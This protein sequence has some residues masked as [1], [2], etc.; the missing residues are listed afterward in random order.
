MKGL[1]KLALVTAIAA[2]PFAA[3]ADLKALDDTAMGDVTGQAGVSIELGADI[4]VGEIAYQ[5]EGFLAINGLHLSGA[6]KDTNPDSRLDNILVKIDVAGT[7]NA[8]LSGGYGL[9]GLGISDPRV[10]QPAIEDGDLVIHLGATELAANPLESVDFGLSIESIGLAKSGATVGNLAAEQGTVLISDLNLTGFIGPIDIVIQEEVAA[11]TQVMNINA[12]FNVEGTI[13]ADFVGTTFG[14]AMGNTRG[15]DAALP[16]AHVQL[17]IG[18]RQN[19]DGNTD[20]L[21]FNVQ[22][23]SGDIDMTDI[24]FGAA[25]GREAIGDL[26]MT[27]VA[28]KAEMVVYGH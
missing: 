24:T 28:V 17:D 8:A 10:Q 20:G 14:F 27:D 22:D 12:Y 4:K 19:A 6:D 1:K 15:A 3:Q 13:N 11:D 7:D 18:T 21:V 16:F 25:A 23:F 9:N 26:Y 5:D 2:V